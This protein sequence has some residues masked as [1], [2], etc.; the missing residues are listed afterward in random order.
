MKE[1]AA[2]GVSAGIGIG[3]AYIVEKT[4]YTIPRERALNVKREL[5]RFEAALTAVVEETRQLVHAAQDKDYGSAGDIMDAYLTLLQDPAFTDG[6]RERIAASHNAAEA[7][8]L[9]IGA[10]ADIFQ[11]M[12]DVYMRDRVYDILDIKNRLLEELLGVRKSLQEQIPPDTVL[13]AD[14]LTTSDTAR[15]NLSHVVGI[16][17]SRGGMNSHTSIVARSMDIPAVVGAKHILDAVQNGDEVLVDG[18]AGEVYISPTKDVAEAFFQRR[19][20]F[21]TG[22]ERLC[23]F[24]GMP[25]VTRDGISVNLGANIGAPEEAARALSCDA[26]SIGLFRSEFLY[27][28]PA[29]IPDEQTQFEAYRHVAT[30]MTGKPVIIRTM[31]VGADKTVFPLL[32]EKEEN[33]ALGYRGIRVQLD[34]PDLFRTQLRAILRASRFGN[35]KLMFPMISSLEELREAKRL[36]DQAKRELRAEKIPFHEDIPVGVMIEV[37]SAVLMADVLARECNFFSI[38][39]NDLIQYTAAVDRTN[40]KVAHLYSHYLPSVMRMIQQTVKA[41]RKAG[42]RCSIC[43]EAAGDLLLFPALLGMGLSNFSTGTNKVLA[44]RRLLSG[45]TIPETRLLATNVLGCT[46]AHE[47]KRQLECFRRWHRDYY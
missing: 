12:E 39:T 21:R 44:I 31:D 11:S 38:G 27:Q 29:R 9:G 32:Y 2:I 13:V 4:E 7:V 25:S 41:A 42:I 34:R 22:Q 3:K 5:D 23:S 36:L 43:G 45:L 30:A 1:L 19:E 6:V 35:M 24:V 40:T 33:P 8:E 28:T 37:P 20:A 10:I 47:I 18:Q 26:D 46:T 15:I 14:D 16:I 17:T